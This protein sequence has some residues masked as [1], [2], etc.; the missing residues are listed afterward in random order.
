MPGGNRRAAAG[1]VLGADL[2]A[3]H[4]D[5]AAGPH[6]LDG[7][8]RPDD[9]GDRA[10]RSHPQRPA[11]VTVVFDEK[12]APVERQLDVTVAGGRQHRRRDRPPPASAGRAP[13][14]GACPLS[15]QRDQACRWTIGRERCRGRGASRRLIP[16]AGA[17]AG[18]P[19]AGDASARPRPSAPGGRAP[20]APSV[21]SEDDHRARRHDGPARDD[22]PAPRGAALSPATTRVAVGVLAIQ[23]RIDRR[24]QPRR[25]AAR[26][27]PGS[28]PARAPRFRLSTRA[29]RSLVLMSALLLLV[30][31]GAAIERG[32]QL[33]PRFEHALLDRRRVRVEQR[34]RLLER[35]ALDRDQ[36]ERG[37]PLGRQVLQQREQPAQLF[38]LARALLGRCAGRDQRLQLARVRRLVSAPSRAAAVRGVRR[39]R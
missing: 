3:R 23:R 25:G 9:G 37:S 7:E 1:R 21:R 13:D 35:Q 19:P 28:P 17:R 29:S 11:R 12:P 33:A 27:R 5:A 30:D 18:A 36:H 16:D 15:A 20:G 10:R 14:G 24:H 32:G 34:R 31:N 22:P 39:R 26:R 2:S 4:R 38:T 8:H 6:R